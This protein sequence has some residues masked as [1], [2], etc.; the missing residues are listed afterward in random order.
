MKATFG[1]WV[2]IIFIENVVCVNVGEEAKISVN[3]RCRLII[4]NAPSSEIANSGSEKS[5]VIALA[6]RVAK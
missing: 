3:Q 1:I 5:V 2:D 4:F 6:R